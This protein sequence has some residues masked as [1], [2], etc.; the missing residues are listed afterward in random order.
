M[1]HVTTSIYI[2]HG[3]WM[4]VNKGESAHCESIMSIFWILTLNIQRIEPT[5]MNVNRAF[6]GNACA[7]S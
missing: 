4:S 1:T 2:G 7:K 3:P 5:F 6:V